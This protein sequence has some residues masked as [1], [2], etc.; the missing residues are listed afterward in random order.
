VGELIG[1]EQLIVLEIA[2]RLGKPAD[3]VSKQMAVLREAGLVSAG[4]NRLYR[5]NPNF[6]ADNDNR[7][8]E[9]GHCLLRLNTAG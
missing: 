6:V 7:T 9:L 3:R 4:C 1:G 5:I 2:Q 8:L